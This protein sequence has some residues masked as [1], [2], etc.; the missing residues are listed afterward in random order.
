MNVKNWSEGS[1]R[2]LWVAGILLRVLALLYG[3]SWAA[4]FVSAKDDMKVAFGFLLFIVL[5]AIVVSLL[6]NAFYVCVHGW[7][8]FQ[9]KESVG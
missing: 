5:I 7:P 4:H 8:E 1:Q 2:G 9:K 3:W 6:V